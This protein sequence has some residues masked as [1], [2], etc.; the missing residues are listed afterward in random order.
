MR[1]RRMTG[2]IAQ[3]I[4]KP[5]HMFSEHDQVGRIGDREDKTRGVGDERADEG[6]RQWL[7]L[8]GPGRCIDCWRHPTAVASFD[9][10]AV[11]TVPTT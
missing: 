2:R 5:R 3:P 4:P 6:I 10:S 1:R 9:R 8:R 7:D 11:T